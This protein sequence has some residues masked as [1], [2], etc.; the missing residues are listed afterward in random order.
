VKSFILR[1]AIA[2]IYG[3]LIGVILGIS[4]AYP[5]PEFKGRIAPLGDGIGAILVSNNG[6]N[7]LQILVNKPFSYSSATASSVHTIDQV[8]AVLNAYGTSKEILNE[9]SNHG[10]LLNNVFKNSKAYSIG[11]RTGDIL[12]IP[13]NK[14][15]AFLRSSRLKSSA[16]LQKVIRNGGDVELYRENKAVK[17]LSLPE[18]ANEDVGFVEV[19]SNIFPSGHKLPTQILLANGNSSGLALALHFIDINT[20]GSL[21]GKFTV[22]ATGAIASSGIVNTIQPIGSLVDKYKAYMRSNY[23]I[24][25]IPE[26]NKYDTLPKNS[27]IKGRVYVVKNVEDALKI[28]CGLGSEDAICKRF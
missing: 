14:Q 21:A 13:E 10:L 12:S 6:P 3:I 19:A 27:D 22:T 2:W 17:I 18:S 11:L 20:A 16:Y 24:M 8:E 1:P 28:I 26:G 9:K 15:N 7:I 4:L 23:D 25:L 5:L